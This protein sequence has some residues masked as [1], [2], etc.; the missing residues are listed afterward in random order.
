M[1]TSSCA[2]TVVNPFIHFRSAVK[3]FHASKLENTTENVHLF[4][5]TVDSVRKKTA[6]QTV[7]GN[8]GGSFV[9]SEKEGKL[10]SKRKQPVQFSTSLLLSDILE[11]I[12]FAK[13]NGTS[14]LSVV[15]KIDIEQ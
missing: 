3:V 7:L 15:I 12:V 13:F 1:C 8:I 9:V 4:S 5:N 11:E 10:L 14:K 2:S 6:I